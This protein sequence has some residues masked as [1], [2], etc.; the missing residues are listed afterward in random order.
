MELL[1]CYLEHL[2]WLRLGHVKTTDELGW[3]IILLTLICT[4]PAFSWLSA[5][6]SLLMT[7]LSA[8]SYKERIKKIIR[9][10]TNRIT[11]KITCALFYTITKCGCQKLHKTLLLKAKWE[12]KRTRNIIKYCVITPAS[13][14]LSSRLWYT[15][16]SLITSA[17]HYLLQTLLGRCCSCVSRVW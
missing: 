7:I 9:G 10:E 3:V 8:D 1:F 14:L 13:H 11:V 12:E 17:P 15:P 5:I 2:D 4:V 16:S 6:T